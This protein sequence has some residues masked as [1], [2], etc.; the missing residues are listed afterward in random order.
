VILLV[1]ALGVVMI[2]WK[3]DMSRETEFVAI[4]PTPNKE[5]E[6]KVT[7]DIYE[8][9]DKAITLVPNFQEKLKISELVA[10]HGC[11]AGINGGFY[12][13][14]N[15]PLGWMAAGGK[16]IS[17]E[18]SS[19]LFNGF[20]WQE[21][22]PEVHISRDLPL[23]DVLWGLQSGPLIMESG[24]ALTLSMARDKPARRSVA[25]INGHG[26]LVI[27]TVYYTNSIFDGPMLEELP[28]VLEKA[29][30]ERG[31]GLVSAVNL[32][33]GSASAFYTTDLKLD[34]FSTVGS[35]LCIRDRE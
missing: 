18:K 28:G 7:I 8:A 6:V 14:D 5:T 34:E 9:G 17:G 21:K 3:S 11:V 10:K 35:W 23:R 22:Q 31:W 25:A 16:I 27:L 15:Q 29:N 4:S 13:T 12:D 20:L 32:D 1:I 30:L 33:G 26:R 2:L 19:N 24:R